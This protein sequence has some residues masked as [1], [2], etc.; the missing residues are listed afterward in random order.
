MKIHLGFD[1]NA[2]SG[3]VEKI[4]SEPDA[5]ATTWRATT[6]WQCGQ[7]FRSEARIPR[8]D[9]EH[10]VAMDEPKALGGGDSAPNMVEMVLG[11]YGCCLTTGLVANAAQRNIALERVEI[12]LEGKLDLRSF[13]G[14][15]DPEKV[16]PGYS[17][18][19]VKVK[20][21][22]PA[23]S[24]DELQD[25]LNAVVRTSPVGSIIERPVKVSAHLA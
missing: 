10:V 25:L 12:D 3:L 9:S 15:A 6:C 18:V 8:R 11:A 19:A 17:D 20:L 24:R 5:G 23:A 7:G 16:W 22:A 4:K 13:L 1:A 14:L 2:L 21:T